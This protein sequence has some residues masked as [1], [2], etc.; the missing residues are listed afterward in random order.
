MDGLKVLVVIDFHNNFISNY[1]LMVFQ[2]YSVSL[3]TFL[4]PLPSTEQL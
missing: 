2:L 4:G 3:G 1:V